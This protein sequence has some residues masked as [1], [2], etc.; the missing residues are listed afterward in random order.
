M[1]RRGGSRS[2]G[3]D[4]LIKRI[5][6]GQV[7]DTQIVPMVRAAV[8][9]AD[10]AQIGRLVDAVLGGKY[11]AENRA[12]ALNDL[13][14]ATQA[15]RLQPPVNIDLAI[16]QIAAARQAGDTN[17]L[18]KIA[19]IAAAWGVEELTAALRDTARDP[20]TAGEAV[21]AALDA[22]ASFQS[23]AGHD[24]RGQFVRD[25][26]PSDLRLRFA[27]AVAP[28]SVQQAALAIGMAIK[29]GEASKHGDLLARA[30]QAVISRPGGVDQLTAMVKQNRPD[31]DGAKLILRALFA[32]EINTGPLVEMLG[33]TA[34]I[35]GPTQPLTEEQ[36]K[37]LVQ[38]IDSQGDPHRG[39]LI[40]RRKELTCIQ[41]H[42]LSGAG[43]NVGPDLS[44]IGVNSPTEYLLESILEPSKG[45]KEAYITLQVL[46][47]DGTVYRGVKIDRDDQ[48]LILRDENGREIV[49]AE[50]DIEDEAEGK[51]LMPE[52]LHHLITEDE[53]VDLVAFLAALGKPGDFVV[54]NRPTVNRFDVLADE[55]LAAK[56]ASL[57]EGKLESELDQLPAE[58]WQ[59]VYALVDGTLPADALPAA[60]SEMIV[61][62]GQFEVVVAGPIGFRA[63][64]QSD[65]QVVVDGKSINSNGQ[66]MIDVASGKHA[67]YIVIESPEQ[68]KSITAEL[69]KPAGAGTQFTI[70]GGI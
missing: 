47:S 28:T 54:N 48:R 5:A 42:A 32:A 65:V 37:A 12:T 16:E 20:A 8:R 15:K 2:G 14:V 34:G 31:A 29:S 26:L 6:D 59:S 35:G 22:L 1:D 61:L 7:Q 27:R 58:A 39:Q 70:L 62:R 69:T 38:R 33:E 53:L 21:D 66:Q 51:S 19:E 44:G 46:T 60:A 50:A 45:I 49:I 40:Y 56:L 30:A 23:P 67:F 24:T 11:S 63:T 43:G 57:P 9:N 52:G 55:K 4:L 10:A 41:C 64:S 68:V 3:D 17:V 18:V 13:L 25:D 36:R